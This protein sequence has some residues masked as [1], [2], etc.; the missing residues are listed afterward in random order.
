MYKKL[1]QNTDLDSQPWL[2]AGEVYDVKVTNCAS[3]DRVW[4]RPLSPDA[5]ARTMT[6][7]EE[8]LEFLCRDDN[9]NLDRF[10]NLKVND[11]CLVR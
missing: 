2:K 7:F 11:L 4:V 10:E 1:T 6:V 3:L 8:L 9:T 5:L